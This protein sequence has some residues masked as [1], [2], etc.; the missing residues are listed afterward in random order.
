MRSPL[1]SPAQVEGTRERPRETFFNTSRGQVPLPGL[2]SN[3]ALPL[4]TREGV[5]NGG[6]GSRMRNRYKIMAD[7][8]GK[9]GTTNDN[10]DGWF[11]GYTPTLSFGAWVGG[12]ERDIHFASMALGQGAN[13]A[14]PLWPTSS[15][16]FMPTI[17]LV[18]VQRTS[19][20]FHQVLT[21][22]PT[23]MARAKKVKY[24][25]E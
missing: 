15:I 8:G 10:S 14:L 1:R 6:T 19:L 16:R 13:S 18:I 4:A 11:I 22:A 12:D 25:K 9:T 21:L 17:R 7:M 2:E 20:T 24:L 5:M 23:F 3:D